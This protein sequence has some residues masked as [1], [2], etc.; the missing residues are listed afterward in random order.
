MVSPSKVSTPLKKP[1][2]IQKKRV[3]R[4]IKVFA[5]D[6]DGV[7][8]N[9]GM[10]IGNSGE[11]MKRFHCHDGMGISSL[12]KAGILT[13]ILTQ[14]NTKIVAIRGKKLKIPEVHQGV[15]DKLDRLKKILK[16]YRLTLKDVAYMGDDLNDISTLREVG[17][18]ATPANGR[19]E[20]KS[21]SHYIC[22]CKGGEGA[23]RE[24]ADLILAA[25][26]RHP[27]AL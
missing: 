4:S 26:G 9:G 11:E 24:V 7:L 5:T 12:Q 3:L 22:R 23:V 15:L 20:A 6:V 14:E 13:V 8:T 1:S 27:S 2:S 19:K 21:V 10:Y 16:Q 17:F 25:Q 18:S